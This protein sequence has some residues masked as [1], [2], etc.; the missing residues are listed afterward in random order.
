VV[1]VPGDPIQLNTLPLVFGGPSIYGSVSGTPIDSEHALAFC[2][3]ENIRPMIETVPL[4]H[5]AAAYVRMTKE[6]DEYVIK[7][8][9]KRN[10]RAPS[11]LYP[12][13]DERGFRRELGA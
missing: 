10:Y 11:R 12:G 2:V 7:T 3:L 13:G 5:T 6:I 8:K 4:E 1:G 9:E